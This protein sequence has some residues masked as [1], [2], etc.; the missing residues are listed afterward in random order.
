MTA[1]RISALLLLS[2]CAMTAAQVAPQMSSPV[3]CYVAYAGNAE[4]RAAA[5]PELARRGFACD[6]QAIDLGQREFLAMQQ[7]P[8]S[9]GA[10]PLYIPG[11]AQLPGPSVNCF[12]SPRLP[13]QSQVTTCQ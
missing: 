9:G 1:A 11:P 4:D 13:G 3:L 12:T 10:F 6:R 7:R 2:G 8:S 5:G